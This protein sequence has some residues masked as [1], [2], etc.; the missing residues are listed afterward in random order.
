[1]SIDECL[2]NFDISKNDV[3][4]IIDELSE[5]GVLCNNTNSKVESYF[6]NTNSNS[7]FFD[8]PRNRNKNQIC[9]LGIPYDG[10]VTGASGCKLSPDKIRNLTSG[11]ANQ[12][13]R[14]DGNLENYRPNINV[15]MNQAVFDLG[16]LLYIAGE[17]SSD[18]HDRLEKLYAL[19]IKQ[20]PNKIVCIGGDHSI[21]Y[22][23]LKCF[24][25]KIK[26]VKIDAHYDSDT[27]INGIVNHANFVTAIQNMDNVD[28]IIHVG[29]REAWKP[30]FSNEKIKV[31]TSDDI[32]RKDLSDL[33]L[34]FSQGDYDFYISIDI[35]VL[36][37]TIAPG[38]GFTIP[39]GLDIIDIFRIIKHINNIGNIV[40]M[41]IVEFNPLLDKNNMTG[42]AVIEILRF[43]IEILS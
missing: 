24:K 17:S 32:K 40:G 38:T 23:I 12:Y 29:V 3:L 14:I 33:F 9:L 16:N 11:Y 28:E 36:D 1:M 19:Q 6:A 8:A 21:T 39:F 31:I 20:F 4:N 35:D 30:I 43:I 15:Y 27:I 41:D 22:P 10:A 34:D 7:S 5:L 42:Y 26:F 13:I 2:N 37:P 25:R 18:L